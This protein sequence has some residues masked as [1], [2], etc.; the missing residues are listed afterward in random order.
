MALWRRLVGDRIQASI[1]HERPR[2][3]R[4]VMLD[5][6]IAAEHQSQEHMI[7]IDIAQSFDG[8]MSV[9]V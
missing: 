8:T 7:L 1:T 4:L 6:R 3:L 2:A 9:N 5:G